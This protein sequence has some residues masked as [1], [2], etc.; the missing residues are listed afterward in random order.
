[1]RLKGTTAMA[2]T[3][4]VQKAKRQERKI[5]KQITELNIKR[6]ESI[7]VEEANYLSDGTKAELTM[8]ISK[9]KEATEAKNK[10]ELQAYTKGFT[11]SFKKCRK[12]GS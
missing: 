3:G 4:N 5:Q 8:I 7:M 12:R 11:K 10:I 2:I 9:I 6:A 1:M